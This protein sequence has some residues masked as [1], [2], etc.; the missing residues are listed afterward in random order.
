MS[1]GAAADVG[2][3][4]STPMGRGVRNFGEPTP[5]LVV[6]AAAARATAFL[7]RPIRA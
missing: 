3:Q 4:P 1:N 2:Y 7:T 5:T 6:D